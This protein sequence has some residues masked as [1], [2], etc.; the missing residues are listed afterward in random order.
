MKKLLDEIRVID[1]FL[2]EDL[3]RR[4]YLISLKLGWRYGW[5]TPQDPLS[6]YWHHEVGFGGKKNTVDVSE[7]VK[8]HPIKDFSEVQ[9]FFKQTLMTDKGKIL[10]FYLN[11]HTYGTDGSPHT[12]IDNDGELTAVLYLTED[13]QIGFSGETVIFDDSGEII[14]SVLPKKNRA[15]LFPSKILHQPRPL[16]KKFRGLRVVLVVKFKP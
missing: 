5:N 3:Y 10:R 7:N 13:W 12:D 2:P 14:K 6:L 1:N 16:S 11:A 9:D 8:K 15:L 4:I